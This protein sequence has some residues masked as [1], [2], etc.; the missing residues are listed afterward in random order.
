MG[1][2]GPFINM[3]NRRTVLDGSNSI[4]SSLGRGEIFSSKFM[5]VTFRQEKNSDI[6]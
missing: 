5:I 6:S 4:K 2:I 1:H 3:Y